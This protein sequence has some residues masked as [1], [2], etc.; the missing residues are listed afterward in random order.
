MNSGAHTMAAS[1]AVMVVNLW[2]SGSSHLE[3]KQK[4]IHDLWNLT[5]SLRGKS[6]VESRWWLGSTAAPWLA[7]T[8]DHRYGVPGCETE[9]GRYGEGRELTTSLVKAFSAFGT[10]LE[11]RSMVVVLWREEEHAGE[12]E[13]KESVTK[14]S[15][16]RYLWAW[17]VTA[18][19]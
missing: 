15:N 8:R 1:K 4:H 11:A 2:Y 13:S 18:E 12:G 10:A 5:N 3:T 6:G 19:L 17:K 9:N 16:R 7:S 14:T